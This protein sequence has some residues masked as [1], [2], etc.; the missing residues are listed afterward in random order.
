MPTPVCLL[1]WHLVS[2]WLHLWKHTSYLTLVAVK[3]NYSEHR[4]CQKFFIWL[5]YTVVLFSAKYHVHWF[6]CWMFATF[7]MCSVFMYSQ[8]T[9]SN[10]LIFALLFRVETHT[11]P[12]DLSFFL[13]RTLVGDCAVLLPRV[14]CCGGRPASYNKRWQHAWITAQWNSSCARCIVNV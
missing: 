3:N 12:N 6:K 9:Y 10:S 5:L 14:L 8:I 7:A 1:M 4:L 11:C 2:E 13:L